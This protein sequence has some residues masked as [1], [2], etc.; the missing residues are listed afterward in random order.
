MQTQLLCIRMYVVGTAGSALIR[1]GFLSEVF[2]QRYMA[3]YTALCPWDV[4]LCPHY[5]TT[6]ES[7]VSDS[8]L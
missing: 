8:L 1:E 6:E 5:L 4:R 3:L 2:I 7:K